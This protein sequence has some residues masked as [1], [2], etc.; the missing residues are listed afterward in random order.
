MPPK[1]IF[2]IPQRQ[3]AGLI[4]EKKIKRVTIHGQENRQW[5]AVF[6]TEQAGKKLLCAVRVQAKQEVR[7]WADLRLLVRW[8]RV[9]CGIVEALLIFKELKEKDK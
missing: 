6:E 8:L 5:Y 4:E 7:Y 1:Q 2:L 3:L 9:D